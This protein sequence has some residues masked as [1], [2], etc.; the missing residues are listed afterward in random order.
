MVFRIFRLFGVIA[1]GLF[2]LVGCTTSGVVETPEGT[3]AES[4][5]GA[6][7]DPPRPIEDLTLASTTG[8]QFSFS[9]HHG[10]VIQIYFGYRSCPDFFPTTFAELRRVYSELEEPADKRKIMF[11]TI[12]TELNTMDYLGKYKDTFQ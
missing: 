3:Y 10:E 12:D 11:V 8:T 6:V 2:L 1:T 4:L 5:R 9:D 7:F